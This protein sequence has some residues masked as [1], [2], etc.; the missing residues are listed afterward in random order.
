MLTGGDAERRRAIEFARE[1]LRQPGTAELAPAADR[2]FGGAVELLTEPE[3]APALPQ[4]AASGAPPSRFQV[5]LQPARPAL[6]RAA[7]TPPVP[8]TAHRIACTICA[9]LP[10]AAC[11]AFSRASHSPP[12]TWR[13]SA[14]TAAGVAYCAS[15]RASSPPRSRRSTVVC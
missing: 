1:V 11:A 6:S 4:R 2:Q 5:R 10:M 14:I 13:V 7:V 8:S 12:S 15:A 3:A 9:P